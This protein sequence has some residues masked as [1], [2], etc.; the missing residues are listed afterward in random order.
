MSHKKLHNWLAF[1]AVHGTR[2]SRGAHSVQGSRIEKHAVC[3]ISDG[4]CMFCSSPATYRASRWSCLEFLRSIK[5]CRNGQKP[6]TR[7]YRNFRLRQVISQASLLGFAIG[8]ED[9]ETTS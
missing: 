5:C 1:T 2:Y 6:A 8:V 9:Q 7:P 4:R 3:S